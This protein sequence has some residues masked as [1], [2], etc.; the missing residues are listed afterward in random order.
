MTLYQY[1]I[2]A[3]SPRKT[4]LVILRTTK[5]RKGLTRRSKADRGTRRRNGKVSRWVE[6]SRWKKMLSQT[7]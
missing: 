5:T 7:R 2:S 6:L 4:G 1:L 3:L